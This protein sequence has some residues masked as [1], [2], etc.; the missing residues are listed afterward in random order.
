[1][2]ETFKDL[3]LKSFLFLPSVTMIYM[4]FSSTLRRKKSGGI[5]MTLS[6]VSAWVSVNLFV[7]VHLLSENIEAIN[8]NL[9]IHYQNVTPNLKGR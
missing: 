9:R 2:T 8:L 1:M 4:L 3:A 7:K 6:S 5:I